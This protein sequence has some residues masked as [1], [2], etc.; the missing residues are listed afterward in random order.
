MNEQTL[1]NLVADTR[2][3]LERTKSNEITSLSFIKL[4][5]IVSLLKTLDLADKPSE[6]TYHYDGLMFFE[7]EHGIKC[8]TKETYDSSTE[9]K[10]IRPQ[11][12]NIESAKE[13]VKSFHNGIKSNE[14]KFNK[15][16]FSN[17]VD[18]PEI[19]RSDRALSLKLVKEVL[20]SSPNLESSHEISPDRIELE[21]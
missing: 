4:K 11:D 6:N 2:D 13:W 19:L 1:I 12:E 7:M 15:G 14:R 3:R 8:M 21:D 18:C 10:M 16:D 17:Y 20:E 5:P 9:I